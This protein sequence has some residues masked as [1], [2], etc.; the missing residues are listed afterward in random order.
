M[1]Q[2][3][4]HLHHFF[5]LE[6]NIANAVIGNTFLQLVAEVELIAA[7]AV[8]DIDHGRR[9]DGV[10]VPATARSDREHEEHASH[11]ATLARLIG[12]GLRARAQ[13]MTPRC[14]CRPPLRRPSRG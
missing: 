7:R 5:T 9:V 6:N 14:R 11:A 10:T 13:A 2:V 8:V 12:A 1:L 4:Q 3:L